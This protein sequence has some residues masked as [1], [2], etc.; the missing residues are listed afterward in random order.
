MVGTANHIADLE[1]AVLSDGFRNHHLIGARTW[2]V[3]FLEPQA[4][5]LDQVG[6]V[7]GIDA[8]W[9]GIFVLTKGRNQHT[10]HA[11]SRRN[12]NNPFHSGVCL[13]LGDDAGMEARTRARVDPTH[14]AEIS[15]TCLLRIAS[16]RKGENNQDDR[17]N[18]QG[19]GTGHQQGAPRVPSAKRARSQRLRRALDCC[20]PGGLF[21]AQFTPLD[22]GHRVQPREGAPHTDERKP[23]HRQWNWD[24]E[25][26]RRP[27]YNLE[28]IAAG[29]KQGQLKAIEDQPRQSAPQGPAQDGKSPGFQ[30]QAARQP[31]LAMAGRVQDP[32]LGQAAGDDDAVD[33]ADHKRKR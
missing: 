8:K 20:A 33:D 3:S 22:N 11:P 4:I 13:D 31:A 1:I 19:H 12:G 6:H 14:T 32:E 9:A 25:Q 5:Q 21:Q 18:H 24:D 2:Q 16:R 23:N 28:I 10:Q 27:A 15:Q 29:R 26:R 17:H 7:L 30:R